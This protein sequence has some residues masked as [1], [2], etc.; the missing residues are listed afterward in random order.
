M[1]DD[2]DMDPEIGVKALELIKDWAD[3]KI[4]E[5]MAKKEPEAAAEPIAEAGELPLPEEAGEV[6]EPA[7]LDDAPPA[8]K[9]T[10]LAR[11]SFFNKPQQ[12]EALPL[13]PKRGPGRPRKAR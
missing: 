3:E 13:P 8:K 7:D 4:G 2:L 1:F 9:P 11:H 5:E 12:A 10:V 6:G